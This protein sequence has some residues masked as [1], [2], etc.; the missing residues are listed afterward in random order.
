LEQPETKIVFGVGPAG[1]GKTLFACYA[2][3]QELRAGN[4]DKI[5][6]TRP[7]VSVDDEN[8]GYLPGTMTHKMDPWTRPI[9]DILNEFFT[10]NEV[11][12]LFSNGKIEVAPLAYMRGRTFKRSFV[13]ADE[14]QNSS[15]NQMLMIA[16]RIGDSSKLVITGD[17]KQ[18]DRPDPT[19][20]GLV[21]FL[22]K[23]KVWKSYKDKIIGGGISGDIPN[24]TKTECDDEDCFLDGNTPKRPIESIA[25]VEFNPSDIER[26]PIVKSI[27][28][29]YSFSSGSGSGSSSPKATYTIIDGNYDA[30]LIPISHF[31]KN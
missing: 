1:S 7:L 16:T 11:I 5:I 13:I 20:N 28:D 2:A 12:N 31:P 27:I 21:D 8:L 15:P 22:E 24:K 23:W 19:A 4:I 6:M 10:P 18:S 30:A 29:I 26:S 9:L 3:V 17:L 25:M 14:M